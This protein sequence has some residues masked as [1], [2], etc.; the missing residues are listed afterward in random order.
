LLLSAKTYCEYFEGIC[1][2]GSAYSG[3]SSE[4]TGGIAVYWAV[5]NGALELISC[6]ISGIEKAQGSRHTWFPDESDLTPTYTYLC[7]LEDPGSQGTGLLVRAE[8]AGRDCRILWWQ[9]GG[10]R[11]FHPEGEVDL[12]KRLVESFQILS[13]VEFL[14]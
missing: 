13:T 11:P 8:E 6:G 2:A 5:G 7:R 1:G 14:G 4:D 12:R 10:W 3:F 9:N